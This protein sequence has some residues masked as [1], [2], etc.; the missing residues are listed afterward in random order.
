MVKEGTAALAGFT[1]R[2]DP[3]ERVLP[4]VVAA[5]TTAGLE[6]P[7]GDELAASLGEPYAPA[8]LRLAEKR[9][10]V[11]SIERGRW[12]A[13]E[14][15]EGFGALLQELGAMGPITLAAVRDRTGLS[16]KFLIPLLE[17]ADRR[18]ITRREGEAR[19]LVRRPAT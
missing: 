1:P 2:V 15:L 9:Q 16:R 4:L 18:G 17:W 3:G 12:A 7:T 5:L 19:V 6:P 10:L 14:A 11:E 13:V 8:A